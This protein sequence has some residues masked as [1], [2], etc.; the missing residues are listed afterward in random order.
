MNV[1]FDSH[2]RLMDYEQIVDTKGKYFKYAY[3]DNIDEL[4]SLM[5]TIRMDILTLPIPMTKKEHEKKCS[6][7]KTWRV[8]CTGAL[9]PAPFDNMA[10][11]IEILA[12]FEIDNWKRSNFVRSLLEKDEDWGA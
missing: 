11:C 9:M 8:D 7:Y 5:D 2:A 3:V 1:Y 12:E 6:L 4:I 10:N